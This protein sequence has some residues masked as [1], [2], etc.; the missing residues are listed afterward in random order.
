MNNC[1]S[2]EKTQ[3]LSQFFQQTMEQYKITGKKLSQVSGVSE[4]H[5]SD[6]RRSRNKKGV[7]TMI[8]W[9]LMEGMEEI[10]P[11]SRQYFCN[12]MARVEPKQYHVNQSSFSCGDII[13][14]LEA[15][16]LAQV[17]TDNIDKVIKAIPHLNNEEQ[18]D[19]MSAL[20]QCLRNDENNKLDIQTTVIHN[21]SGNNFG[22]FKGTFQSCG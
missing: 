11:G 2:E 4:N 8:L 5:I 3:I 12:L 16:E 1:I 15:D 13:S 18:A 20:A 21:N 10:A 19:I 14:V 22:I 6:F 7:S 17:L 9:K